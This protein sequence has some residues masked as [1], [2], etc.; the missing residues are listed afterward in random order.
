MN[1][2]DLRRNRNRYIEQMVK[3]NDEKP[4]RNLDL[5]R[6]QMETAYK[7]RNETALESLYEAEVVE[8]NSMRNTPSIRKDKSCAI[9]GHLE[10]GQSTSPNC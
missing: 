6:I 8:S 5:V 7:S 2:A 9:I 1:L 4:S 10:D 3:M